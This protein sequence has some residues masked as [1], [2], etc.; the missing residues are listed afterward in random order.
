VFPSNVFCVHRY[1]RLA[2]LLQ[3]PPLVD[4]VFFGGEGAHLLL[5]ALHVALSEFDDAGYVVLM[6]D[7]AVVLPDHVAALIETLGISSCAPVMS[8]RPHNLSPA[9]LHDPIFAESNQSSLSSSAFA[10][11]DDGFLVT[12]AAAEDMLAER[13][14]WLQVCAL[15]VTAP[16]LMCFGCSL[17]TPWITGIFALS[18]FL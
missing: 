13:R 4:V 10:S 11:L 12:R 1:R 17:F 8:F 7:S 16:P 2:Q 6:S 3:L 14:R 5:H 18:R 15:P 9:I